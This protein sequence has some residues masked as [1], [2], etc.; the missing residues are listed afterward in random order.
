MNLITL[1]FDQQIFF[2]FILPPIIF[3]AGYNLKRKSFFKYFNYIFIFGFLGTIVNFLVVF[4][5]TYF[6]NSLNFFFFSD[7]A[8]LNLSL[9]EILLFASVISASDTIS[10]LTF[11]KEEENPKLFSILFGE[12]IVNDA[13][14]IVLYKIII[15]TQGIGSY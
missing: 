13:V 5:L 1:S 11:I 14:C 3:S 8:I 10:A 7:G 12:G 9:K 4:P 6:A 15:N 2:T